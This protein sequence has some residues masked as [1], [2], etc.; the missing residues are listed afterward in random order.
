VRKR[1]DYGGRRVAS[2][3]LA[4]CSFVLTSGFALAEPAG[5]AATES[6]HEALCRLIE[7]AAREHGVAADF[8]TNLIWRESNFSARA[9]S[10]RG[11]QGIAQVMPSTAAERGLADPFDPEQAIPQAARLLADLARR[12]GNLGLAAAAYNAGAGRVSRWLAKEVALPPATRNFVLLVTGRTPED[13]AAQ[14]KAGFP[15]SGAAPASCTAIVASVHRSGRRI[16]EAKMPRIEETPRIEEARTAHI[17][18]TPRIE[19]ARTTHIEETPRIEEART[20]HIEET[21]HIEEAR[22]THIEETPRIEETSTPSIDETPLAT[23]GVQVAGN[24]SKEIA[25]ASFARVR[26]RFAS[27]LGEVRPMIIG[28]QLRNRGTT[29]FYRVRVPA[30]S[31]TAADTLCNR[32]RSAGG[33]CVVLRNSP[34]TSSEERQLPTAMR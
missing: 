34:A 18:E 24:F 19:E 33:A 6:V 17:G 22:T 1:P 23:W 9:V 11:A 21:P 12:F 4:L 8:L 15:Q 14:G 30:D 25:L 7:T 3:G 32:I 2:S 26:E 5:P 29:A 13:W 28:T 27:E 16:E 31:R 20:T 10:R